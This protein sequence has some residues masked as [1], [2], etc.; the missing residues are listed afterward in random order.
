[1]P[2]RA[3]LCLPHMPLHV[4]QRGNNRQ[5]CF[6]A[7]EDYRSCL[8]WLQE[9]STKARCRVHSRNRS[10]PRRFNPNGFASCQAT[11]GGSTG[12]ALP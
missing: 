3:R 1:M 4:I 5:V 8:S 6:F 9:Y 11:A 2:R 10:D 12:T 7:D